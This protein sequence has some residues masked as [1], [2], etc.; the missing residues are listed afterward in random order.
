[1]KVA[2]N[3]IWLL[4]LVAMPQLLWAQADPLLLEKFPKEDV[5][6]LEMTQRLD[7]R[8]VGDSL[9]IKNNVRERAHYLTG[10]DL[11]LTREG[12]YYTSFSEIKN[13]K[14]FTEVPAGKKSKRIDV[15]DFQ[16]KS[17][18]SS[19]IFFDDNK[20]MEFL[21]PGVMSGA[22]TQMEYT[23]VIKDPRMLGVFYFNFY[24]PVIKAE[25]SVSFP[26][27]VKVDHILLGNHTDKIKFKETKQADGNILYTWTAENLPKLKFEGSA[28]SRS[29]FDPH[30][31]LHITSAKLGGKE[32]PILRNTSDLYAWYYSLVEEINPEGE[33]EL[34]A[35]VD[36]IVKD[37]KTQR[38]K[39]QAIFS[40]VQANIN[41][42]AFEDGMGGFI[43]RNAIDVCTK[44]YGDCKDMSNLLTEMLQLGGLEAY[45]TWIGTRH[46]PYTYAKVPTPMVD[47]HMITALVLEGDTLF[48]D[49]TGKYQTL[50]LPT[51]MIQGKEALIGFGK[52]KYVIKEVPVITM[53]RNR[54]VDSVHLTIAGSDLKTKGTTIWN[55]YSKVDAAYAYYGRDKSDDN[56]FVN[57]LTAKGNNKYRTDKFAMNDPLNAYTP[58][59][60]EYEGTIPDYVRNIAGKYY[61]AFNLDKMVTTTPIDKEKRTYSFEFDYKVDQNL[62]AMLEIP[63][64]YGIEYLPASSKYKGDLFGYDITYQADDK[65]VKQVKRVYINTLMLEPSQ[66][67][68]WNEFISQLNKAHKETLVLTKKQ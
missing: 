50:D 64:G 36:G 58:L 26:P 22:T 14:A 63:E 6:Y 57:S 31:I 33:K 46:K 49:A 54:V 24:V 13:L 19:G 61:M 53:E 41:Y 59:R 35:I 62:V 66:F 1:M 42:V 51:D 34:K 18:T 21:Y 43:P 12:I 52:D 48:L 25:Y 45:M 5:V 30:I 60:I 38:E 37:K 27:D 17:A 2:V 10:N 32:Q 3:S 15:T 8:I 9:D 39:A 28:P 67:D 29:Y 55:G 11:S 16:V 20:K 44:K 4:L 68:A 56:K 65:S 7:I 40:W 47:N 23:E